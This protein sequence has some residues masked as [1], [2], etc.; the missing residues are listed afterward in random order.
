[1]KYFSHFTFRHGLELISNACLNFRRCTD[2]KIVRG[3]LGPR[4]FRM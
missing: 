1:M 4:P 2:V 3:R